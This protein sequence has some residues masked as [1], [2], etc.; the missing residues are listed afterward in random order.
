MTTSYGALCSDFYV[1]LKLGM[2]MDLPTERQTILDLFDRIKREC[3]EMDRFRRFRGELALESSEKDGRSQWLALR[4]NTI[5]AGCVNPGSLAE[6][7]RMHRSILETSPY[8]LS[9]SPLDVDYLEVLFGFDLEAQG[10]QNAIVHDA[11]L[12]GT[13]LGELVDRDSAT[14]IDI[15][16]ML[17]GA[18]N[19]EL[20]LQVYYE[21]K[22]RTTPRQI[23]EK[24]FGEEPISVYLTMRK[25]TPAQTVDELPL[26]FDA[27]ASECE[28][29]A[30]EKVAPQLLSPLREAIAAARF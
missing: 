21:V 4:R 3:P 2:K 7:Y 27:L 30:E 20:D 18:I 14:P 11:L 25:Y 12:G 24:E 8:F 5:R 19:E 22:T 17:G 13:P 6:A 15:Q 28:R 29:L 1:N 10:N 9:I 26:G 23:R 16:P